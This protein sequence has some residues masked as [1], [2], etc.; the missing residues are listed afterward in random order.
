MVPGK[1]VPLLQAAVKVF[2]QER[3]CSVHAEEQPSA[4][5]SKAWPRSPWSSPV[6]L[7]SWRRR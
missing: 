3:G 4:K 5:Q 1:L 2:V 6:D 7:G